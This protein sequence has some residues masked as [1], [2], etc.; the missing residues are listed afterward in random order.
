[1]EIDLIVGCFMLLGLSSK[2]LEG[3]A[4]DFILHGAEVLNAANLNRDAIK[5]LWKPPASLAHLAEW[6]QEVADLLVV[7]RLAV[8]NLRLPEVQLANLTVLARD[9]L[10]I[11]QSR[12]D[13]QLTIALN[14][15]QPIQRQSCTQSDFLH[16]HQM[17]AARQVR[18]EILRKSTVNSTS[19]F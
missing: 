1:M 18:A 11:L 19:S 15:P 13:I 14:L 4:M 8:L 7:V 3:A 5:N 16:R 17:W 10:D 12:L 6:L 9:A 2:M